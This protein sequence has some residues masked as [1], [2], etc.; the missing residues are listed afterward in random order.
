M[1]CKHI[2]LECMIRNMRRCRIVTE[3][4]SWLTLA[5][6]RLRQCLRKCLTLFRPVVGGRVLLSPPLVGQIDDQAGTRRGA[7]HREGVV[8]DGELLQ[9]V[10]GLAECVTKGPVQEEHA[11]CFDSDSQFSYQCKRD[12]CYAAGF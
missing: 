10:P 12:R 9:L 7:C 6:H 4:S 8:E 1:E 5:L 3:R 2:S 11:G